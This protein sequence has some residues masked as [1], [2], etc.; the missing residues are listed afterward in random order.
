[1]IVELLKE[2]R[3]Q[4]YQDSPLIDEEVVVGEGV[5]MISSSLDMLTNSCLGGIMV[6]LIFLEGL[7]EE[8][9]VEFMVEWYV[10]PTGRVIVPTGRYIVPT[11]RVIVATGKYV[12]PAGSDNESDDASVHNEATNTPQ[13]PDIQPQIITI[14]LN[15]NAKFPYFK[16]DE[17]EQQLEE[18]KDRDGKVII[19][20]PTTAEEHIAVQRESKARTTLLQSIPDDHVADFHYMD[21]ARDIWNAV[22]ARFGGNAESKKMR[23]S[24]LKQEFSEFRTGDAG[25][26][27]L[28]GVTSENNLLTRMDGFDWVLERERELVAS[29]LRFFNFNTLSLQEGRMLDLGKLLPPSGNLHKWVSDKQHIW[30]K[31]A[32]SLRRLDLGKLLPPSGNLHKWVS[33]KQHIW[34][35]VALSLRRGFAAVLAVLVTR[36]SQSRQHDTLVKLPMDI[37]LKINLENQSSEVSFVESTTNKFLQTSHHPPF[38]KELVDVFDHVMSSFILQ[39]APSSL[40][41]VLYVDILGNVFE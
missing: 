23:K 20:P 33:D 7:D 21:D 25:E 19:L 5:V 26:F 13:Q 11:G 39:C 32:L 17:Y 27:A 2:E 1:M 22:K 10:V 6:S 30:T 4:R 16:K 28:M 8:A 36:A 12:V 18:G 24:M 35:K 31:V 29:F 40:W 14:A 37:R 15:N 41:Q 3:N 38:L 34:T 9:F